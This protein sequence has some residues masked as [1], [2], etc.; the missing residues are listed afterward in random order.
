MVRPWVHIYVW[1][2]LKLAS[3]LVARASAVRDREALMH[4]GARGGERKLAPHSSAL[5]GLN[6][7]ADC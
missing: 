4:R 2:K 1:Q 7:Y 6:E 3:G 5:I